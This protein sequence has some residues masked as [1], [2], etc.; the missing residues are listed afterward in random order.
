MGTTVALVTG[1]ILS[2]AAFFL[3]RGTRRVSTISDLKNVTVSRQW[4][5]EHQGDD[6]S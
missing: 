4:L 3:W 2:L 6:R 1:L 5:M